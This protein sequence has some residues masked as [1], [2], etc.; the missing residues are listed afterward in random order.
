M[1]ELIEAIKKRF[2]NDYEMQRMGGCI[3]SELKGFSER[4]DRLSATVGTKLR[5]QDKEIEK[6]KQD[7][8]DLYEMLAQRTKR[9]EALESKDRDWEYLMEQ[10]KSNLRSIEALEKELK[11]QDD[12]FECHLKMINGLEERLRRVEEE[13]MGHLMDEHNI[14][15]RKPKKEPV[16][17]DKDGKPLEKWDVISYPYSVGGKKFRM[18]GQFIRMQ[19]RNRIW[20]G[21]KDFNAIYPTCEYDVDQNI[22]TF[23]FRPK[24]KES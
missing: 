12:G 5:E 21:W 1:A 15:I 18:L 19:S 23:E 9:I 22:V 16:P 8:L 20:G 7:I 6:L 11:G 14:E 3:E 13:F 17:T 2:P 10:V 4:M 24:H